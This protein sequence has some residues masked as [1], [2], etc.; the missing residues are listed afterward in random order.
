MRQE[1]KINR[2]QREK[3]TDKKHL[4]NLI[5]ITCICL[6]IG[7]G[8]G[9]SSVLAREW[10]IANMD[11]R[12]GAFQTI[13]GLIALGVC[14]LGT[15]FLIAAALYNF[16]QAKKLSVSWDGEDEAVMDA[17]DNRQNIALLWNNLLMIFSFF[18][19]ALLIG[20]SG[21]FGFPGSAGTN[22][23]EL[24]MISIISLL[25]GF[26]ILFAGIIAY[27]AIYKSVVDLQKKLNPEKQGSIF[28]F[29]FNK[30]WEASSDEAE[31]QAMYK[32]SYKAYQAANMTCLVVW[33]ITIFAQIIINAGVFPVVCVCAIWFVL[34]VTYS[35]TVIQQGRRR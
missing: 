12:D 7:G 22:L 18:S 34:N 27:T 11:S 23:S 17:I 5:G 25:G 19:F 32:A 2:M 6:F 20:V 8:I 14:V 24:S 29:R 4:T 13:F 1:E 21:I 31:K 30:K 35:I 28:D 3:E 10:I 15:V 9:F 26:P 33:M 16:S